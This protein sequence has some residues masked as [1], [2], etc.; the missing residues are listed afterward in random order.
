MSRKTDSHP[1][2]RSRKPKMVPYVHSHDSPVPG[3]DDADLIPKS[4]HDKTTSYYSSQSFSGKNTTNG[5]VIGSDLVDIDDRGGGSRDL[6][7]EGDLGVGTLV[8]KTE[9]IETD[10]ASITETSFIENGN[11]TQPLLEGSDSDDDG[12]EIEIVMTED[13]G[14]TSLQICMQVTLPYIIAGFGMVLAGIVL[15]IVQVSDKRNNTFFS[16]Y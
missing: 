15:D 4:N 7:M 2:L 6:E 13:T 8:Q 3:H 5:E 16:V 9:A 14:E 11:D 10:V 12:V 1:N